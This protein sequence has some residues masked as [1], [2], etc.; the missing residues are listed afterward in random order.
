MNNL[1][2]HSIDHAACS[3]GTVLLQH[4]ERE[5]ISKLI[6]SLCDVYRPTTLLQL[7]ALLNTGSNA[8]NNTRQA[9]VKGVFSDDAVTDYFRPYAFEQG[10]SIG[11][12]GEH[13]TDAVSEK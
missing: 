11:K 3:G 12:S 10:P 2:Y 4:E 5:H 13:D 9:E 7:F 1:F 8:M 6:S